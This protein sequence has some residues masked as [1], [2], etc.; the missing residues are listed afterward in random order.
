M[1]GISKLRPDECSDSARMSFSMQEVRDVDEIGGMRLGKREDSPRLRAF[2]PSCKL[3]LLSP[4]HTEGPTNTAGGA[5]EAEDAQQR[6][7][8]TVPTCSF[9]RSTGRHRSIASHP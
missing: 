5:R 2:L 6:T 9:Q 4:L 8:T 3:H 1:S 7:T